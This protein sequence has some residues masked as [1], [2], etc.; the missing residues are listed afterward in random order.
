MPR[1]SLI[2][3]MDENG[4]I[5]RDN[6]LPWRLS[7]DLQHFKRVTMGKPMIMGRKCYESIGKPLPGRRNIVLTRDA[8]WRAEGVEVVCS[9]D[10]ALRSTQDADEVMIVGGAQIYSLALPQVQRIHLTRVH[11]RLEGDTWFPDLVDE[12]WQE[13]SRE[14][15]PAD[16]RNEYPHSFMVL[17]RG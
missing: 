14:S 10:E 2:V 3:A 5:G 1:I 9:L 6:D 16:E 12:E 17:E 11:A 7:S 4:L 8:G 13:R 15:H